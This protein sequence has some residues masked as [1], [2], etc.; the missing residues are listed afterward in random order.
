MQEPLATEEHVASYLR[1]ALG[2][3]SELEILETPTTWVCQEKPHRP[4]HE[5]T[6]DAACHL[7]VEPGGGY[8]IYGIEKKNSHI[9]FL[10]RNPPDHPAL[11][12]DRA[13]W[14]KGY[15]WTGQIYPK[16]WRV[17]IDLVA[18]SGAMLTYRVQLF[19]RT[20][21]PQDDVDLPVTI[22][23]LTKKVDYGTAHASWAL[24]Q[25]VTKI[26]HPQYYGGPLL[27]TITL[28]I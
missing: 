17:R 6:T 24:V 14:E 8:S 20:D 10:G 23:K 15:F 19:S 21:P 9:F 12:L 3:R 16:P 2:I 11:L 18:D 27:P 4:R 25:A 7:P 13:C 26:S 22:N 1:R 5:T 28:E